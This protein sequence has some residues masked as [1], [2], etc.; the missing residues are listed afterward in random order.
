MGM[1]PDEAETAALLAALE[2]GAIK[3]A[4]LDVSDRIATIR[5]AAAATSICTIAER[6][7]ASG[8][9]KLDA[10]G[11]KPPASFRPLGAI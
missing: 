3:A 6:P 2:A 7:F 8:M 10:P 4:G 5:I 1:E 11:G 9:V